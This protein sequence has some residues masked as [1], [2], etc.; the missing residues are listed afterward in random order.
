MADLTFTSSPSL[1][2]DASLDIANKALK[3]TLDAGAPTATMPLTPTTASTLVLNLLRPY[4]ATLILTP[5]L[6]GL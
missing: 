3:L 4:G 2:E 1:A 5:V 6:H